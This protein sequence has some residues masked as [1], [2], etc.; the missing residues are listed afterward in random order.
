MEITSLVETA[1]KTLAPSKSQMRA[2]LEQWKANAEQEKGGDPNY[3]K[4]LGRAL[5]LLD[6]SISVKQ[7]IEKLKKTPTQ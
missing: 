7:L 6:K 2:L 5:K 1:S 4:S 3:P